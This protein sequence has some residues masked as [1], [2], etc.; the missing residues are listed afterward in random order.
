MGIRFYCPNGH[1]LNVKEFQAGRKGIC[2]FCQAKIQIPTE[3]TR[4]S[5]KHQTS[6]ENG[7]HVA[8]PTM[9][10]STQ[11][12]LPQPLPPATSPAGVATV[13]L[14]PVPPSPAASPGAFDF[15]P[16]ST[17]GADVLPA[18]QAEAPTVKPAATLPS[19]NSSVSAGATP[20]KSAPAATAS[21]G[22]SPVPAGP[23]P[24]VEAGDAAWYV[25][26]T[27][28][29][30]YGPAN[31]E[32]MRGW[33]TEGR[34]TPGSLVWREGWRDWREAAKVFPQT[35][36]NHPEYIFE[37]IVAEEM[38][39][40]A[41]AELYAPSKSRRRPPT[42]QT[43]IF[44]AL[45]AAVVILSLCSC[46]FCGTSLATRGKRKSSRRRRH[47]SF[48]TLPCAKYAARDSKRGTR[49]KSWLPMS[50]TEPRLGWARWV[51]R[52]GPFCLGGEFVADWAFRI[53]DLPLCLRPPP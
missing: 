51:S 44:A 34:I 43:W 8:A 32:I 9:E 28:G 18:A 20:S 22:A 21:D 30:Q 31:R 10:P 29:G 48:R 11:S 50:R 37:S 46:G 3:S 45:V 14:P 36:A 39:A 47:R 16:F 42:M 41:P 52:F 40:H 7:S 35:T 5:A 6:E 33:L 26:A 25:R 49:W 1:K 53:A 2:P 27:D 17:I 19:A 4:P 15:D 23:D 12:P 38:S 13:P 24:L